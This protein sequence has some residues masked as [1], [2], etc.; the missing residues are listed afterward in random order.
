MKRVLMILLVL[1]ISI[2]TSEQ[3]MANEG[4]TIYVVQP[5]DSLYAISVQYNVKI[6]EIVEWNNIQNGMIHPGDELVIRPTGEATTDTG[7]TET[8]TDSEDKEP[9]I[10]SM[11]PIDFHPDVHERVQ[12]L[13]NEFMDFPVS[14]YVEELDGENPQYA[15]INRESEIYGASLPRIMLVAYALNQ[16]ERGAIDWET[17]F[18]YTQDAETLQDS[19]DVE[20][21]DMPQEGP[22]EYT[23]RELVQRTLEDDTRAFYTLM[24]QVGMNDRQD[25]NTFTMN[26]IGAPEFS[27]EMSV[28]D[29]TDV[30]KYIYNHNDPTVREMLGFIE[31]E[32]T[33]L[34]V[35]DDDV[36][37]VVTDNNDRYQHATDVVEGGKVYIITLMSD[38]ISEE[39]ISQIAIRINQNFE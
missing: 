32:G 37:Q 3:A 38:Q 31:S 12:R 18:Q 9:Y 34:D 21:E 24:S 30:M 7:D 27:L 22:S 33:Y 20:S 28:D 11:V 17:S 8:D 26:M 5:G 16:V 29:I 19:Y 39:L 2:V 25:F 6:D 15:A 4:Q 10:P 14:I 23:L 35:L 1:L 36:L 13:L